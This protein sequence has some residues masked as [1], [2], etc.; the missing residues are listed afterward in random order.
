[1]PARCTP[2]AIGVTVSLPLTRLPD[3]DARFTTACL[4]VLCA[5]GAVVLGS[6]VAPQAARKIAVAMAINAMRMDLL[7]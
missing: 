1:M 6:G 2:P 5:G 7:R 3:A 4:A